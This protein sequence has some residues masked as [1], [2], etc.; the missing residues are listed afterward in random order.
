MAE[1]TTATITRPRGG[2]SPGTAASGGIRPEASEGTP[3]SPAESGRVA[4]NGKNS[5]AI[6]V[7]R[8]KLGWFTQ[9]TADRTRFRI[10]IPTNTGGVLT[11]RYKTGTVDLR[12]PFKKIVKTAAAEIVYEVKRGEYGE[13]FAMA[14]GKANEWVQ[15]TFRQTA[16]SRDG[17]KDPDKPLVPWDFFYWP[18]AHSPQNK[19]SKGAGDILALYARA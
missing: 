14:T 18:T 16:F 11:I 19:F 15:C 8:L 17:T 13:F 1:G 3:N 5:L 12:R 10:W 7:T 2:G 4:R 6:P 9:M